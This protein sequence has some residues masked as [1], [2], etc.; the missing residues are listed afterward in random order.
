MTTAPA[1]EPELKG[2]GAL[3]LAGFELCGIF[4][5]AMWASGGGVSSGGALGAVIL[6]SA[7]VTFPFSLVGSIW[8]V[9]TIVNAP[10]STN[11]TAAWIAAALHVALCLP[12]L[13]VIFAG[14]V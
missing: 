5:V 2:V 13:V 1:E 4:V 8:A 6:L 3:I 9:N 11:R 14:H 10:P 12:A 7:I